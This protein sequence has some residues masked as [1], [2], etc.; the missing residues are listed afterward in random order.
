MSWLIWS[1]RAM[2]ALFFL[3]CFLTAPNL[4]HRKLSYR[5]LTGWDYA[6]RGLYNNKKG[7]PENS[8]AGFE[9]AILAGYGIELDVRLTVDGTLIVHHD[10]TLERSCG[11]SKR[12][13]DARYDEICNYSLFGTNQRI[14]TF[15]EVLELVD[16]RVPLIV[17]LKTDFKRREL[18]AEVF[19]RLENYSGVFC[20]ESFDP[21]AIRWY[22]I[23]APQVVRGQLAF[24]DTLKGKP[25][26]EALKRIMLG[27]LLV[28]C[29]GRPDFIAYGYKTDANI[30]YRFV[31]NVFRPLLA[32]WTV[33]DMDASVKLRQEYDIQIF[34]NI[35]P[36]RQ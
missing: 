27:C 32:A 24:M 4:I 31:S 28:D 1:T 11:I 30:A 8:L 16:G 15:D 33:Q 7:I 26:M 25:I 17:E 36:A 20:V 14:P 29:I 21:F 35:R 18:A 10:E 34:E 5:Q 2:I 22:R 13:D 12:V 23:H 19:D 3:F 9:K 6:H